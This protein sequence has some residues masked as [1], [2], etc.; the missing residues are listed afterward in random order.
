M[1]VDG[2]VYRFYSLKMLLTLISVWLEYLG[3]IKHILP[4]VPGE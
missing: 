4:G 2:F 1:G 3:L